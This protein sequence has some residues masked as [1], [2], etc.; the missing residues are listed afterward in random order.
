MISALG[1][2]PGRITGHSEAIRMLDKR[3]DQ[4][5]ADYP[6]FQ[7]VGCVGFPRQLV[8]FSTL[9]FARTWP[10]DEAFQGFV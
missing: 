2:D 5:L 8:R 3:A 4:L 1:I 10:D 7:S 9:L 6:P